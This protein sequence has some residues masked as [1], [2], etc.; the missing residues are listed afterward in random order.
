M[1]L[2]GP[3]KVSGPVPQ[4]SIDSRV[5]IAAVKRPFHHQKSGTSPLSKVTRSVWLKYSLP[6]TPDQMLHQRTLMRNDGTEA[7]YGQ[8][9]RA[10]G[11][12]E[13]YELPANRNDLSHNQ[14]GI[15]T[16]GSTYVPIPLVYLLTV[17]AG[18]CD[19]PKGTPAQQGSGHG[20]TVPT[21]RGVIRGATH[22]PRA[23]V[24]HHAP[25]VTV[26]GTV[27]LLL[28]KKRRN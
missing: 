9:T 11:Q 16:S 14:A 18:V 17:S 6:P 13:T 10:Y 28:Q 1:D 5:R 3:I 23:N 7:M 15:C 22:P 25:N 12:V 19:S 21:S 27:F 8:V 24:P 2:A 4:H 20:P 26:P